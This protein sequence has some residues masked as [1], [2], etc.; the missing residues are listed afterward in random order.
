MNVSFKSAADRLRDSVRDIPDFPQPG[1]T[2]RDITPILSNGQMFRL[3][4]TIFSERYQRKSV[5]KIAAIDARG[6]IFAGAVANVL[7]IGFVPI[8]KK[9]KLPGPAY[10]VAY[11][12]EYGSNTLCIHK[13]AIKPEERVV[14]IDDVLATGGTAA[15]AVQLVEKC[16]GKIVE[17]GFLIELTALKGREKL[18]TNPVIS[19]IQY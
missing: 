12:L 2:F 16:G 8:R 5:D 17:L 10:E 4:I 18:G 1:I 9:G 6:F 11:D 14:I 19:V 3:T 15:A 7:G 13:D